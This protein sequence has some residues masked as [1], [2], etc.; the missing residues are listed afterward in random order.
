[1][2]NAH[3]FLQHRRTWSIGDLSPGEV[4][5]VLDTAQQ[6]KATARRGRVDT[7]LRGRRIALLSDTPP[8]DG[9]DSLRRAAAALGAEVTH[10]RPGSDGTAL[11]ARDGALRLLGR[12]YDAIDCT[13]LP[14]GFVQ[15]V[16]RDSGVPV[17]NGLAATDHPARAIAE[18]L[19]IREHTAKPLAGL[20]VAISG[21]ID[22]PCG[23]AFAALARRLGITLEDAGH[24]ANAD[25]VIDTHDPKHWRCTAAGV[26]ID[27]AE[28]AADHACVLQALLL[29]AMS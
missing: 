2:T 15:R 22:S 4:A 29:M 23:Q 11:A 17:F 21:G 9:P 18:L 8:A 24:A 7:P 28:A 25:F 6:L 26:P 3:T 16:E 13:G 20:H 27:D 19:E 10:L 1:M 14:A 5:A 12:L